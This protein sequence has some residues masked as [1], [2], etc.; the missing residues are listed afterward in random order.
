M[1]DLY[2]DPEVKALSRFLEIL[3]N[4]VRREVLCLTAERPWYVT[5]LARHCGIKQ[6]GM[7]RH[8]DDLEEVALVEREP[9]KDVVRV[10]VRLET[11]EAGLENAAQIIHPRGVEILKWLK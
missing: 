9:W 2:R 5:E 11:L 8:L 10:R 4:P 3:A 1:A 6:S 7:S